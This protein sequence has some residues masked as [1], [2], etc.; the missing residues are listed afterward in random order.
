M[1]NAAAF[2]DRI[3]PRYAARP[4]SDEAAYEETLERVIS[5]LKPT[6]T[7]L[8]IGC[9]TGSTALRLAPHVARM[10]ATD[11][12]P[13]MIAIAEGK[14][15]SVDNLTVQLAEADRIDGGPFDAVMAFNLLHLLPD[16]DHTLAVLFA[17]MNPGAH[18]IS[19]TPCLGDGAFWL[20]LIV[21]PMQWM[22][23]APPVNFT[24]TADLDRAITAA[25][26][27]LVETGTQPDVAP[28]RFIVARKP[29]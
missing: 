4:I 25:G 6:D 1:T 3:A 16:L 26:F 19:K 20:R 8:E 18:L 5:Y 7:A 29:V 17:H 10:V 14:A 13:G 22:G 15:A 21:P 23:K 24:R 27:D 9:G 12:A 11:F 2:W 28:R